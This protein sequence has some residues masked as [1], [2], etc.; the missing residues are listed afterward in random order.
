[1]QILIFLL[2]IFINLCTYPC[3]YLTFLLIYF[4]CVYLVSM[5]FIISGHGIVF[6]YLFNFIFYIVIKIC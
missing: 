6:V 5:D 4:L 3:K 1:M 2:C